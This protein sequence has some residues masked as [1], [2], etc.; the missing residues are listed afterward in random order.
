MNIIDLLEKKKN[1]EHLTEEEINYWVKGLCD[2]SIAD[3]QSSAMLMAI[4]I[5]GM[6]EKE[7]FYLTKAMTYS[8]ETL[9]FSCIEGIK[10]D[11][12]S[13]GG[14][15]DKTSMALMPLLASC[16]IKVAK[17][18]GGALSFMGGTVDKL[19]SIPGMNVF[20]NKDKLI[21]QVQEIGIAM[22][23]QTGNLCPADKK[24]YA[25][26]DVTATVNCIP[27]IVSSIMS[28]KL[29]C[30]DD[31][32][33]LDVKFG[34]GAAM[35]T[36]DDAQNLAEL[37]VSV[38]KQYGKNIGACLTSMEQP[39][40]R[41]VGNA[42][43]VKEAIDTLHGKGPKDFEELVL[44][45]GAELLAR[46]GL[47]TY[48]DAMKALIDSMNTG[49]AANLFKVMIEHQGGDSRVVDDTSLLPQAQFITEI[50]SQNEGYI[51]KLQGQPIGECS[52]SLGAGRQTA[53]D[54]IDYAVGIVLNKKVGDYVKTGET[55]AYVHHNKPLEEK[56]LQHFN[57]AY[58]FKAT[59]VEPRPIIE[60]II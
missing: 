53:E 39:L 3:Y 42:L 22:V 12:H 25:L 18:S 4:C 34:D 48:D 60:K 26:R 8:G 37:M 19:S 5:N 2:G 33:L 28:K 10:A 55:L 32:I 50:K 35:K 17:M 54:E 14:V 45:S 15:G 6:D 20:L 24:L 31:V 41:A 44:K 51:A 1:G 58:E 38:G 16:G 11:K 59:K 43:E 30:G 9:D 29:A 7:T 21:E 23:G 57:S 49:K 56:W 36:I 27:L 52:M 40:G 13:S 47:Y 46:A